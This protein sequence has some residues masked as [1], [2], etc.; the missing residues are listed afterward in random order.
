VGTRRG[1]Q[2]GDED[3]DQEPN[4]CG[5]DRHNVLN[6]SEA[7]WNKQRESSLWTICRGAQSVETEYWNASYGTDVLGAFFCGR[8]GFAN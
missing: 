6:T 7:Q 3:D 4:D 1:L 5:T 8:D 2:V